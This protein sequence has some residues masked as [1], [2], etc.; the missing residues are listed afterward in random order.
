MKNA[1]YGIHVE[2]GKKGKIVLTKQSTI[3]ITG[4]INMSK[5]NSLHYQLCLEGAK[6]LKRKKNHEH[7]ETPW[8]YIAVE[9]C[10]YGCENPDIWASNGWSTIVVEVK[11]RRSD[12]KNDEK[13][14]WGQKGNEE[15]IA[16]NYR[17]YLAPKGLLKPED[18]SEGIGLLEYNDGIIERVIK[19]KRY[20]RYNHADMII[21]SSI[22]R[23]EKFKE[24]IYNYRNLKE[25]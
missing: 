7:F 5:T 4:C 16:G 24:G 17:Y 15:C 11:T 25:E 13:K 10:V 2:I 21:M 1:K 3:S 12:F 23:R 14:K 18:L 22:L 6:W 8:K 19:A 20:K 9:L